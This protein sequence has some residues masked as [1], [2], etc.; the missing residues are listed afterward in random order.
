MEERL[1]KLVDKYKTNKNE[2]LQLK[3]LLNA[4]IDRITQ[5]T[6]EYQAISLPNLYNQNIIW[7]FLSDLLEKCIS[8]CEK[9]VIEISKIIN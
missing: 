4:N 9:L 2:L 3:S 8:P 5:V 6:K 7:H 1:S